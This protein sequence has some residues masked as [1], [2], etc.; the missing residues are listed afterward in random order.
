M[1]CNKLQGTGV[2]Y[3]YPFEWVASEGDVPGKG[4]LEK[5]CNCAF[6]GDKTPIFQAATSSSLPGG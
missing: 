1:G 4:I 5:G 6:L 3:M 2:S